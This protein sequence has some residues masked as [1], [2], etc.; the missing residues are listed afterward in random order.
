MND[1]YSDAAFALTLIIAPLSIA[2]IGLS[3]RIKVHQAHKSTSAHVGASIIWVLLALIS[4][5]VTMAILTVTK[6]Q[7]IMIVDIWSLYGK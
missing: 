2:A 5:P 7:V 3:N 4:I 1:P 6:W